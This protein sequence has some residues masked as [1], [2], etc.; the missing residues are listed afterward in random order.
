LN[1]GYEK[2]I[3]FVSLLPKSDKSLVLET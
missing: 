2:E 1:N 3:I